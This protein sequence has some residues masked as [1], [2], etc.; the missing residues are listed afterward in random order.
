MFRVCFAAL[1]FLGAANFEFVAE[2][3]PRPASQCGQDSFS[4]KKNLRLERV[5]P[6]AA[7]FCPLTLGEV[8][9]AETACFVAEGTALCSTWAP[10]IQLHRAVFPGGLTGPGALPGSRSTAEP[11]PAC[12]GG[13]ARPRLALSRI[14]PS[15][16]KQYRRKN[17]T[18]NGW[19]GERPK[20][21]QSCHY[22]NSTR[23]KR[24][25]YRGL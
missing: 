12:A 3:C 4:P 16:S 2:R 8:W 11:V 18:E 19:V 7:C 22:R 6:A 15:K 5:F 14:K 10:W 9:A 1:P 23:G 20:V 21:S 13:G 24:K 25:L 17:C